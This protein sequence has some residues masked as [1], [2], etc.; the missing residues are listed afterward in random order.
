MTAVN[1]EKA[2]ATY[3]GDAEALFKHGVDYNPLKSE[4]DPNRLLKET[5]DTD[6]DIVTE[7]NRRLEKVGAP[8]TITYRISV[9]AI[10]ARNYQWETTTT[11]FPEFSVPDKTEDLSSQR[12]RVDLGGDPSVKNEAVPVEAGKSTHSSSAR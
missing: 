5:T 9:E 6:G 8:V 4:K 10:Q 11:P 12:I 2:D 1:G 7:V 3:L